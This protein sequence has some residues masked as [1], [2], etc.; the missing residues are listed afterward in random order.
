MTNGSLA[1]FLF[2][3]DGRPA[4]EERI[5]IVLNVAQGI[6]YLHEECVTQII[7]CDI[8]PE[9]ILMSEQ[10]CA[11]LADFGLAKLLKSEHTR[12]HT[13]FRGTRGYI[14]PEW[15]RNMPITVKADVYSFGVVLLEIICCR[16]SVN[17]DIPEDQVVLENWVYHCLEADELHKLVED[18]EV[19]KTKLGG[20]IK[21]VLWCIQYEPSLRPS[22]KKVVLMLEG[23]VEIPA[24]PNPDSQSQHLEFLTPTEWLTD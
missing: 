2:R 4:W 23:T 16:R 22:M 21:I 24:P 11:K 6:L 3:S 17:M 10:K 5:G 8:K 15:L 19:D 7:H 12:T 14:A 9:N 18:E 20:M 1:D 13:G